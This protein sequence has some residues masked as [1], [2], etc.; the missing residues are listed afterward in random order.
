MASRRAF[1]GAA[2][3][4]AA[5]GCASTGSTADVLFGVSPVVRVAVSWSA[6]ELQA[7]RQ[8]LDRLR[9]EHQL[10]YRVALIPLGDEIATAFA[11]RT[12]R[13]PDVVMLPQP[14][15]VKDLADR[16]E[17]ADVGDDSVLRPWPNAELW[18]RMVCHRGKCYGL[19]FKI[20]HKSTIWYRKS[21]FRSPPK[22]WS[23]WLTLNRS[24]SERG[25]TP[26]ALPG[27]DG[28][29]LTDSFENVLLGC[30]RE[31]YDL[32]AGAGPEAR[33][34]DKPAVRQAL[35]L[36]GD[37]WASPL[38]GGVDRALVQQFPDAVIEV[39]GYRRAAMVVAPDFAEP[40]VRE[41]AGGDFD[42]FTFPVIDACAVDPDQACRQG[43]PPLVVGGDVAV[44][45]AG[46]SEH[47]RDLVRLLGQPEAARPWIEGR[48]GFLAANPGIPNIAYS[49]ALEKLAGQ[50]S[51]KDQLIRFDLSDQLGPLG[52]SSGLFRVLQDFLEQVGGGRGDRADR[53]GAVNQAL[54][55]LRVLEE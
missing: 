1:L 33:L 26:L 27:A 29:M 51:E 15:L 39:F 8:V 35:E 13:R 47:A 40:L 6:E 22:C 50:I 32:L 45:R 41:L 18:R 37:M 3:L 20:A 43:K 24:L 5:S 19:P 44:L 46:A 36:L 12:A 4:A 52:G 10:E 16:G 23:E 25:I 31:V 34:S 17:L 14:G 53:A 7:F 54:D 42:T 38:A 55:A 48:G 2:V 49:P 28:W 30:A 9:Y 11:S 21:M